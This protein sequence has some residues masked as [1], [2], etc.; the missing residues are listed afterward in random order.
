MTLRRASIIGLGSMAVL[1]LV[2]AGLW[3]ARARL[4][5]QFA[6][7][8][9]RQHGV[10]ASVEVGSLGLSGASGR[11]A[12]GPVDAPEVAADS[13]ELFFDPLRWKPYLVEV[14][15]KNP[16]VR[17]RIG[18]DGKVTLPSLQA[19]LDSLGQSKE[20]SPYVSDDLAVSFRGL[21]ALLSTPAGPLEI[22]GGAKLVRMRPVSAA[23]TV[24][25]AA[26]QWRDVTARLE[27]AA[28]TLAQ[29]GNGYRLSLRVTGDVARGDMAAMKLNVVAETPLMKLGDIVIANALHIKASAQQVRGAGVTAD[30]VL[31]TLDAKGLRFG[32]GTLTLAQAAV[33]AQTAAL[34]G[35]AGAKTAKLTASL[36][37]VTAKAPGV[38]GDGDVAL[39]ATVA[40]P[41]PLRKMVRDLPA[42]AM[43]APLKAA[44]SN[45]LGPFAVNAKAQVARHGGVTRL[46][47]AAP[48]TVRAAKGAL[49]RVTSLTARQEGAVATGS[50][51][52]SLSG[53]GL[54][55]LSLTAS[56]FTVGGQGL[57]AAVGLH[58]ALDFA[59]F[60]GIDATLD[61]T[62]TAGKGAVAFT[63]VRCEPLSLAAMAALATKISGQICPADAPL[64][65]RDGAGWRAAAEA[66]GVSAFLPLANAQAS[67]AAA[68]L[69][70]DGKSGPRGT[71]TLTAA[72]IADAATP[73]R[74]KPV[75]GSGGIDLADNVW[76]GRFAV[77]DGKN[78]P[79]GNAL[80]THAMASGDGSVHV[81]AMLNFVQNGLQPEDLS[82][83]LAPLKKADGR[84][85]FKGDIAWSASGL[86]ASSGTLTTKGFDFLTPM[87]RAHA[88]DTMLALTSLLP[89][90]T[91]G[92]QALSIARIDWTLPF[93]DLGL[94]FGF[95]TQSIKF[96]Q[97]ETNIA[98]GHVALSPFTVTL[99]KPE[100][101]GRATITSLSL[102]PLI[103]A[104]NL[105]GKVA[106]EGRL[107]GVVPFTATAG[108]GGFRIRSGHL[109]ADGPGRL[110]LN[111]SLWGDAALTANMAQDFAYQALEN[112]AFDSLSADIDSIDGG[113]LKVV[114]HIKGHNAP[115]KPQSSTVELALPDILNGSV[116]Q[117]PIPLPSG[118]P[119]E[120]TLDTSLNFD[121][122]LQS[123]AQA[124]S[125]ALNSGGANP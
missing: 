63:L 69:A 78:R 42:L 107:S 29:A 65:A 53:G 49:L 115:P 96:D 68:H 45:N 12:L 67:D 104:S 38:D 25:P 39:E 22:D 79:L 72:K 43:D 30:A 19:W 123:Y 118:V 62:L 94:R 101:D 44:L 99:A 57:R 100:V 40:L 8:Y 18:E 95:N 111:R 28:L 11:F 80:L 84:A 102:A 6:Q 125:K 73:L 76:R 71:V 24:K 13:I 26:L 48:L 61:G 50:L 52:A 97:V 74:F 70:F 124:W 31:L 15:L 82:P 33:T 58:T 92:G 56:N 20:K 1:L 55:L 3:L 14:R 34:E 110:S 4:A 66:K 16:V 10:A 5:V 59:V 41:E 86:G 37:G 113:R 85:D 32:D 36:R 117:R 119:I 2:V 27:I 105:S 120:L 54:P 83:L 87:G 122:L 46:K 116:L 112:L 88:L 60:K 114:F 64:F 75:T 103:A 51:Q 89:P 91:S 7:S 17:A 90:A 21:R 108:P 109:A 106:M 77:S 93:S 47:L 98:D 81:E 9:F 121:E 35:A 23:L